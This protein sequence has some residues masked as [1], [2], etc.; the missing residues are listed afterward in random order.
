MFKLAMIGR[1]AAGCMVRGEDSADKRLQTAAA[2]IHERMGMPD[3]G[4]PQ[5]AIEKAKCI[6]VIPEMKKAAF[7]IGAQY[8]RGF[9]SCK[10]AG[11]AWGPPAAVRLEGGSFGLQLGGQSTDVIM[12]VMSKRG[13]EK[14]AS[15]KFT[16][17]GD[18]SVAAGP[19]GRDA[20]ADTDAQMHAEVLSGSRTPGLVAGLSLHGAPPRPARSRQ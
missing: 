11:G 10:K 13:M 1:V 4:I 20:G 6:V 9:A 5:D 18:A 2:V 12:L 3:K 17:G 14:L 16:L 19:V 15:D 8:G 7:V